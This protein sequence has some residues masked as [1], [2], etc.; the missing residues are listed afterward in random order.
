M[1]QNLLTKVFGKK[2]DRDSKKSAPLVEEIN[3]LESQMKPLSDDQLK[4][5]TPDFRQR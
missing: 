2:E 3:R 1:L 4:A 5:K